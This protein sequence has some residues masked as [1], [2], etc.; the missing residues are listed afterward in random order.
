MSPV[1]TRGADLAADAGHTPGRSRSELDSQLAYLA[2]VLKTPLIGRIWAPLADQ[3]PDEG[4]TNEEYL[5]AVLARQVADREA[6]GTQIRLAGA[7]FPQVK[8]IEEF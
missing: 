2:R 8:T 3:A 5:A 4:W 1:V 7:H 6:N